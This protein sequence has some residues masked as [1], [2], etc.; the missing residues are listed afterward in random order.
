M[1][2]IKDEAGYKNALTGNCQIIF[3]LFGDIVSIPHI[4]EEL[5]KAGKTV[6][7]HIDLI[8]GLSSRDIAVDY[9]AKNTQA[10]GIISTRPNMMKCAKKNHLLAVQRFFVID[11]I[12]FENIEKQLSGSA[13]AIEILPGVMPKVITRIVKSV[14]KPVI[15]GGLIA[16]K[17]D[18]LSALHAG[19]F[20][21]SS[22]K[23]NDWMKQSD[24]KSENTKA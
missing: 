14:D 6:F 7:V 4:V 3:V 24:R 17:E 18:V 13:D 22:S 21:I 5:K 10:D 2:A 19:A 8:D 15:A 20:A 12:A 1:A 11:S 9:I 23:G 16:D